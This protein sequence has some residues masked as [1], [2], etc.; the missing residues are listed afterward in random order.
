M[1][2]RSYSFVHSW[3][4]FS[5]ADERPLPSLEAVNGYQPEHLLFRSALATNT[6]I[7]SSFILISAECTTDHIHSCKCSQPMNWDPHFASVRRRRSPGV[8][9]PD[10]AHKVR[11]I[12]VGY[13]EVGSVYEPVTGNVGIHI[14]AE[15]I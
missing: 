9:R 1:H 10:H 5:V 8:L 7:T 4:M 2:N 3:Q 14:A 6:R 12:V 15:K 11:R 13:R